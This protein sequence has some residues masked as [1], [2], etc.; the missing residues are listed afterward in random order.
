MRT[1]DLIANMPRAERSLGAHRWGASPTTARA[2]AARLLQ[3][4]NA[5]RMCR[6]GADAGSPQLVRLLVEHGGALVPR[7]AAL[8]PEA[9]RL[10]HW[11]PM[12]ETDAGWSMPADLCVAAAGFRERERFFAA[13]LVTLLDD[14]GFRALSAELG[15]TPAAT[16]GQRRIALAAAIRAA[17]ASA[18]PSREAVRSTVELQSVRRRDIEALIPE[19]DGGGLRFSLRLADGDEA[20][21][22]PREAAERA[23]GAFAP[24]VVS[25][26]TQ[27]AVEVDLPEVRVP[28]HQAIGAVIVFA[29]PRT[30]EE[31]QK[32]PAVRSILARRLD[33]RTIATRPT[34]DAATA[35]E[36]L[37]QLGFRLDGEPA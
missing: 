14:D 35:R 16:S 10:R 28:P 1:I 4:A 18:S 7:Q 22:C 17:C 30:A 34:V 37:R 23:G 29:S 6:R 15:V 2:L 25:A 8:E 9:D 12:L 32:L 33:D 21:V 13:T 31:A 20:P 19:A 3:P 27:I 5:L 26:P 11:F 36:L 24:V